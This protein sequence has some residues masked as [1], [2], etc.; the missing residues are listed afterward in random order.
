MFNCLMNYMNGTSCASLTTPQQNVILDVEVKVTYN[1]FDKWFIMTVVFSVLNVVALGIAILL[2]HLQ[3]KKREEYQ[4]F[5]KHK[6]K[7]FNNDTTM[8]AKFKSQQ[9]AA[10]N[11]IIIE[12][13]T[14]KTTTFD[15][16]MIK[17][18]K[19][20]EPKHDSFVEEEKESSFVAH[21]PEVPKE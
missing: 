14:Q 21:F 17:S 6:E 8:L 10:Q 4:N 7:W 19:F 11:K 5:R 18:A 15:A 13:D 16:S 12:E 9:N 2:W 20:P 1:M 3:K